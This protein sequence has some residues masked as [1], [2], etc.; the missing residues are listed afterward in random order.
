MYN[1]VCKADNTHNSKPRLK[2]GPNIAYGFVG[3]KLQ[4]KKEYGGG[5]PLDC[6]SLADYRTLW[7]E[8]LAARRVVTL[9]L[10]PSVRDGAW[11]R[12]SGL[13]HLAR[14][15]QVLGTD[16]RIRLVDLSDLYPDGVLSER[17]PTLPAIRRFQAEDVDVLLAANMT[18]SEENTTALVVRGVCRGPS[19]TVPAYIYMGED[20]PVLPNGQRLTERLCGGWPMADMMRQAGLKVPDAYISSSQPGDVVF[21]TGLETMLGVAR[22]LKYCRYMRI[23]QIGADCSTFGGVKADERSM[24]RHWG[25]QTDTAVTVGELTA[26]MN[27]LLE[28]PPAWLAEEVATLEKRIDMTKARECVSNI[29]ERVLCMLYAI[30]EFL[31]KYNCNAFTAQCWTRILEETKTMMCWVLGE[32]SAMGIPESCETD[33][34]GV[35]SMA[36]LWGAADVAPMFTDFTTVQKLPSG[37][38]GIL[39]WHCGPGSICNCRKGCHPKMLPGYI[40]KPKAAGLGSFP[41]GE[42]G[43]TTTWVRLCQEGTGY[44]LVTMEGEIV[45]GPGNWGTHFWNVFPVDWP[46]LER[47][48]HAAP[49]EHHWATVPTPPGTTGVSHILRAAAPWMWAEATPLVPD[50]KELNDRITCQAVRG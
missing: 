2:G 42:I 14:T 25:I 32:L 46:E 41:I 48:L 8:R 17:V 29:A 34:L 39:G 15:T 5:K 26:R 21:N 38:D 27:E 31:E 20:L 22:A 11:D 36:L 49:V 9:G 10:V 37:R 33:K 40:L 18:Y 28:N 24:F 1:L 3:K 44:E 4:D 19:V 7:A 47:R 45:D 30:L 50:Y 16:P 23:L 6:C 43:G 35:I 13:A 12:P